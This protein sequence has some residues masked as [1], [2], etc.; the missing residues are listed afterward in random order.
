MRIQHDWSHFTPVTL[1]M[2]EDG[3]EGQI[4]GSDSDYQSNNLVSQITL[5]Y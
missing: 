4:K 5:Q 3:F 2:Q 1:Q